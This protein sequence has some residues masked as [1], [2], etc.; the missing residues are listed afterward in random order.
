MNEINHW[1]LTYI[2]VD[3]VEKTETFTS[4]EDQANRTL[5]LHYELKLPIIS[6]TSGSR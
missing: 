2:D 6:H 4:E 3:G 5:E 1:E